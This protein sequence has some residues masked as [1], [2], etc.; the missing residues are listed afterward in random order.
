MTKSLSMT[1]RSVAGSIIR[2]ET[3]SIDDIRSF[4]TVRRPQGLFDLDSAQEIGRI[5]PENWTGT[6]LDVLKHAEIP[7]AD[8]IFIVLREQFF[9]VRLLRMFIH[10]R[11]R[12]ILCVMRSHPW[13]EDFDDEE[14]TDDELNAE[15]DAAN[16]AAR[17]ALWDSLFEVG[18]FGYASRKP[19]DELYG[20][21]EKKVTTV[22][23]EQVAKLIEM[24]GERT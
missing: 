5:L 14:V 18:Q 22:M 1:E 4:T 24:L 12:L 3:I 17:D 11:S 8:K 2:K 10:W 19:D 7:D 23:K 15:L 6:A 9:D 13:P 21:F 20:S 16:F